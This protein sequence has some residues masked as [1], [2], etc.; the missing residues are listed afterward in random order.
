MRCAGEGAPKIDAIA[1]QNNATMSA[2]SRTGLVT[3]SR[4]ETL[5]AGLEVILAAD[6]DNAT[7]T[8]EG[9]FV[10]GVTERMGGGRAG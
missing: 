8:S 9:D 4:A 3:G 10:T 5:S 1:K 7:V 2:P 6:D